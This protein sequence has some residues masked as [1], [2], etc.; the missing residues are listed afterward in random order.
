MMDMMILWMASGPGIRDFL[1]AQVAHPPAKL[2]K[3]LNGLRRRYLKLLED[4][5]A[6]GVS[7][8][9]LRSDLDPAVSAG[10]MMGIVVYFHMLAKVF[11]DPIKVADV[12]TKLVDFA[13]YGLGA[14]GDAS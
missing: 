12:R 11:D 2:M 7:S 8:G 13:L 9:E 4:V 10:A 5:I 1:T 14:R 3:R 6:E